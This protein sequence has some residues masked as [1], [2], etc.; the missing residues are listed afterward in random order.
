MA[1]I[2]TSNVSV[3]DIG[4]VLNEAG[5]SVNVNQPLTFFTSD[6]KINKWALYKPFIYPQDFFETTAD[7]LVAA[8]K[9]N[10]GLTI[11]T[12]ALGSGISSEGWTYALP[13]GGSTQPMR[14]GDFRLYNTNAPCPMK[15]T[16]ANES[17]E[18]YIN[19]INSA[20][21]PYI[22][23]WYR[24]DENTSSPGMGNAEITLNDV[25]ISGVSTNTI[26]GYVACVVAYSSTLGAGAAAYRIANAE[27]TLDLRFGTAIADYV[28]N[29]NKFNIEEAATTAVGGNFPEG[30]INKRMLKL[31]PKINKYTPSEKGKVYSTTSDNPTTAPTTTSGGNGYVS[32][33]VGNQF[34][35]VPN[36]G[37]LTLYMYERVTVQINYGYT[38]ITNGTTTLIGTWG[39]VDSSSSY[40]NGV[41]SLGGKTINYNTQQVTVRTLCTLHNIDETADAIV[42][43]RFL[44]DARGIFPKR[45][46]TMQD[47]S[48]NSITSNQVTIPKGGSINVYFVATYTAG[49]ASNYT[50]ASLTSPSYGTSTPRI[51]LKAMTSNGWGAEFTPPQYN[52]LNKELRWR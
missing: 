7:Y 17:T 43:S 12:S 21:L 36:G 51:S 46:V 1:V 18:A 23:V 25:N 5:G 31:Y 20:S 37:V 47:S 48:G 2:G 3:Q 39:F 6:A 38:S 19:T 32:A 26:G 16:W 35:S 44:S 8:K 49:S 24:L 30:A 52:D 14:I 33:N 4:T 10:F 27:D 34:I 13:T 40:T 9:K 50:F 45:V 42:T 28:I 29:L 11:P 15:V 41:F 22:R